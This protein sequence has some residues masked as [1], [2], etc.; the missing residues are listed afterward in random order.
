MCDSTSDH[1]FG[2]THADGFGIDDRHTEFG[3]QFFRRHNV[4]VNLAPEWN[5]R[6]G[7]LFNELLANGEGPFNDEI[8]ISGQVTGVVKIHGSD[9]AYESSHAV[10]LH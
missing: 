5:N 10:G 9:A 4:W 2:I 8:V 7:S 1:Q 6:L 3:R